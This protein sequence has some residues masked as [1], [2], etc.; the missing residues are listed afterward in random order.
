MQTRLGAAVAAALL[1]FLPGCAG[2]LQVEEL[3]TPIT[4][5]VVRSVTGLV[6]EAGGPRVAVVQT[7]APMH[8]AYGNITGWQPLSSDAG[9]G[10]GTG[11]T[12]ANAIPGA[13]GGVASAGLSAGLTR[14]SSSVMNI[15]V[16]GARAIASSSSE[17]SS[18][19]F[20]QSQ[21][22][23]HAPSQP[24]CSGAN[25]QALAQPH[26]FVPPPVQNAPPPAPVGAHLNGN[27]CGNFYGC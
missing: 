26:A 1:F 25:C 21:G 11:Q 3:Y 7:L 17:A 4:G 8:D 14:P 18:R 16:D 23:G 13:I 12:V 5:Q 10:Y 6:D 24:H 22:R 2:K 9:S 15:A 27:P 19:S 20:S